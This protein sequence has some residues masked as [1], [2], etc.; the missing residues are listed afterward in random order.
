[1]LCVPIRYIGSVEV[2]MIKYNVTLQFKYNDISNCHMIP[3]SSNS[4][5]FIYTGIKIE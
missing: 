5:Y 1:M 4:K 3:F 2:E